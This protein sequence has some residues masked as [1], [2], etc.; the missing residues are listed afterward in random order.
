MKRKDNRR[1]DQDYPQKGGNK[2][3]SQRTATPVMESVTSVQPDYAALR[4]YFQHIEAHTLVKT[5]IPRKHKR[6]WVE[7]QLDVHDALLELLPGNFRRTILKPGDT[8]T[9]HVRVTNAI[10]CLHDWLRLYQEIIKQPPP[11]GLQLIVRE[12]CD[13]RDELNRLYSPEAH[14]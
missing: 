14:Q 1:L 11:E 9:E 2:F 7:A 10:I 3:P 12:L 4:R 8:R 6:A 5:P 13:R